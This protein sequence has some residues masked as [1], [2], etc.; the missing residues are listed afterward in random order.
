MNEALRQDEQQT[1]EEKR[2]F[3]YL[4]GVFQPVVV[5]S[6]MLIGLVSRQSSRKPETRVG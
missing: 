6:R 5:V 3:R 2:A 4:L 1:R